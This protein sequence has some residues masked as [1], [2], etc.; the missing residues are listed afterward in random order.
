MTKSVLDYMDDISD[1][2]FELAK[3]CMLRA[4]ATTEIE[5]RTG[6]LMDII[7]THCIFNLRLQEWLDSDNGNFFHDLVGIYQHFDRPSLTMAQ[8]FCPRFAGVS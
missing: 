4:T 2:D 5:D 6:L 3:Q 1:E 8:G 7:A